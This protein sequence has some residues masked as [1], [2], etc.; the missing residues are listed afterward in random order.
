[1]AQ[2]GAV[3]GMVR[4]HFESNDERLRETLRA[5]DK[6]RQ[7]TSG[8]RRRFF[9]IEEVAVSSYGSMKSRKS[10]ASKVEAWYLVDVVL[11]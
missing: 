5:K 8:R 2:N 4:I 1:M 7:P 9:R 6:R 10:T 3:D 11:E